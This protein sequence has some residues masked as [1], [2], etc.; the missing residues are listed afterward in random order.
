MTALDEFSLHVDD[1]LLDAGVSVG[2]ILLAGLSNRPVD[3]AFAQARAAGLEAIIASST[4]AG[5]RDDP[6][7]RG[8]RD[9]HTRFGASDEAVVPSPESLYAALFRHGGLRPINP[10]VDIYNHVSLDRRLS[11]GAHALEQLEGG[12]RLGLADGSE[13]FT[14]LGQR[15]TRTVPCGEYA[16]IDGAGR[17]ICRLE[18]RQSDHS[19]VTD[20]T[21]SAAII[22]QGNAAVPV[23]AVEE[24]CTAIENLVDRH[25]GPVV[26]RR[27]IIIEPSATASVRAAGGHGL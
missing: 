3:A 7:V 23:T 11:C 17:I 10:L 5:L 16:Y 2:F 18:C 15:K 20:S 24:A 4:L 19:A 14:P 21:T 9:L 13:P 26:A 8:Y 12:I 1:A 25:I 22:V 6:F 27:R